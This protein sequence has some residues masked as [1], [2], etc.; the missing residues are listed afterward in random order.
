MK[1]TITHNTITK[2]YDSLGSESDNGLVFN[3]SKLTVQNDQMD[4]NK[5]DAEARGNL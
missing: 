1:N 3:R 2:K 4:N 5:L